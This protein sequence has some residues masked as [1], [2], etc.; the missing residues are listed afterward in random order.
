MLLML[1]G[2]AS[3]ERGLITHRIHGFHILFYPAK[4][5]VNSMKN[6]SNKSDERVVV[7]ML[8]NTSSYRQTDGSM[9]IASM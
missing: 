1:C 5:V 8:Q 3:R 9:L 4:H 6:Y 7:N 2:F